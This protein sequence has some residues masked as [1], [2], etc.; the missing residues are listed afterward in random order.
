M[1]EK[2]LTIVDKCRITGEVYSIT[3][4]MKGYRLWQAG[5]LIQNAMPELS[6]E[7]REFLISGT[8]PNGW[9]KLFGDDE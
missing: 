9:K 4:P 5:E 2:T 8:S 7:D 6:A 1:P 3:V